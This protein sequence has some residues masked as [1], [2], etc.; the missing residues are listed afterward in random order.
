MMSTMS[1]SIC[2]QPIRPG[3]LYLD[4]MFEGSDVLVTHR[5]SMEEITSNYVRKIS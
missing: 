5:L 1:A 4:K 3:I 2:V